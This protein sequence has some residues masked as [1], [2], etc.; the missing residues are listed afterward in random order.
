MSRYQSQR[1]GFNFHG[2]NGNGRNHNQNSNWR[3]QE[4]QPQQQQQ[5]YAPQPQIGQYVAPQQRGRSGGYRRGGV[6]NRPKDNIRMPLEAKEKTGM[7]GGQ[8]LSK[9]NSEFKNDPLYLEAFFPSPSEE[10]VPIAEEV[11]HFTGFDGLMSVIN[12]SYENFCA[13][14]I[15]FKRNVS[16]ASY[17]Y[18]VAVFAW[19]RVLFIKRKNRYKL[20]TDEI[21]FVN[22]IYEEGNYLLPKSVTVYLAGFGNFT[23]PSGVESKFNTKPYE[24]DENGYFNNFDTLFYLCS[25]YPCISI[26]AE[27]IMRDIGYTANP[28]IGEAWSPNEIEHD[29]NTRCI[30]YSPSVTLSDMQSQTLERSLISFENFPSDCSGLLINIRLL[31]NIQKYLTEIPSLESGP[32]PATVTGSVGQFVIAESMNTAAQIAAADE[33]GSLSY[34][35]QSPL[36]CPGSMSYLSGAFL[37]RVDK[38]LT[39][40]RRAFFYPYT[41]NDPSVQDALNLDLLNTEWSGLFDHIYHYSN[42]PFKPILRLK[43]FCSIDVKVGSM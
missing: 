4:S 9:T 5:M 6:S 38:T 26:F 3:D 37:Y 27:R 19:A 10:L 41:V 43:R 18:Y 14:S 35:I 28:A 22:M 16:H 23:I 33:I 15:N 29:W 32:I 40:N 34:I 25:S 2:S 11:N 30:G 8:H 13:H 17:S 7:P 12:E 1:G 31:N 24:Y 42:V 21:E 20:T 36:S 39:I